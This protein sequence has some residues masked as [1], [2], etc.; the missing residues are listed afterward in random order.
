MTGVQTCALPIYAVDA[1]FAGFQPKVVA[2][3]WIG[4]D[5][6][7]SLGARESGGGLALPVWL[8]YME[9]ALQGVPVTGYPVPAGV[10]EVDG[11][12]RYTEFAGGGFVERIGLEATAP[13][14]A[15]APASAP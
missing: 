15:S 14:P 13:A 5:E 9:R 8:G 12:W 3:V 11:D 1:W 7:R 2:V 10:Q 4:Y 6:P